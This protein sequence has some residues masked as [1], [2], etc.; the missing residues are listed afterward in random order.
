MTVPKPVTSQGRGSAR[1]AVDESKPTPWSSVRPL[2][3]Q[4]TN[5]R[6][7]TVMVR[8]AKKKVRKW[9][10]DSQL[11]DLSQRG[12]KQCVIVCD[13]CIRGRREQE[14]DGR[15]GGLGTRQRT[16]HFLL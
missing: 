8:L 12:G 2:S 9:L 14:R 11:S 3:I 6:R 10:V 1:L 16:L 4:S 5:A 15:T 7:E 13:W